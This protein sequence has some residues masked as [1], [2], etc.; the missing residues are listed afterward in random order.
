MVCRERIYLPGIALGI[1]AV[2]GGKKNSLRRAESDSSTC[3]H[4]GAGL[5]QLLFSTPPIDPQA[6]ACKCSTTMNLPG[7]KPALPL[8]VCTSTNSIGGGYPL[9]I[10]QTGNQVY[11][12][13]T[14][15]CAAAPGC[16]IPFYTGADKSKVCTGLFSTEPCFPALN[17]TTCTPPNVTFYIYPPGCGIVD[18][19]LAQE[20]MFSNTTD[21]RRVSRICSTSGPSSEMQ[22]GSEGAYALALSLLGPY[23]GRIS[24][25]CRSEPSS[26]VKYQ[27]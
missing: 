6:Q 5:L 15:F 7:L 13:D 11:N 10:D 19:I 3:Q 25:S 8:G 2:S 4:F 20:V 27:Y 18:M 12:G 14:F 9:P 1:D 17:V 22:C 16:G 24:S 26:S 21:L 23:L